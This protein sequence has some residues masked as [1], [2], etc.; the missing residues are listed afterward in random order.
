MDP[1]TVADKRQ[2]AHLASNRLA[3]Q[4]CYHEGSW[5]SPTL[6]M[7][8]VD[9]HLDD[10]VSLSCFVASD[11]LEHHSLPPIAAHYVD[12]QTLS[13]YLSQHK[14]EVHMDIIEVFGGE[15]GAAKVRIRRGIVTCKNFDLVVGCDLADLVQQEAVL[16]YIR[17]R[18]PMLIILGSPCS[19]FASWSRLNSCLH[20]DA[21]IM[22]R[23]VGVKLADCFAEV[24]PLQLVGGRHFTIDSPARSEMFKLHSFEE[25]WRTGQVCSINA[26][27][28]ASGPV[29]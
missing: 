5:L 17:V 13:D 26:P 28:S 14:M 9:E 3:H 2:L 22:A 18:R 20:P 1:L 16:K 10:N 29:V 11:G 25:I 19:A 8:H 12:V 24:V 21:H 23:R 15:A 27:Q 7:E 6:L 4:H